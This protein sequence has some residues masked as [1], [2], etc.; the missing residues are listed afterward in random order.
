[1][2]K[3]LKFT[4]FAC[5]FLM[6]YSACTRPSSGA[7]TTT[8]HYINATIT[9]GRSF[10]VT[11]PNI[12]VS[13]TVGGNTKIEGVNTF[14]APSATL[15]FGFLAFPGAAGTYSLAGTAIWG[16][17]ND[18]TDVAPHTC[19]HGTLTLTAVTPDI[20]GTFTFTRSDSSVVS[21][22]MNVPAP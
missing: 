6:A 4:A 13:G 16:N 1:M 5:T 15:D 20:I 17:Y 14:A 7:R 12:Y 18:T 21:G 3:Y 11:D 2:N 9:G 22:S 8:G 19:V 10:A